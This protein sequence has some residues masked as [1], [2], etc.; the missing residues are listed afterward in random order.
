MLS[1]T[2]ISQI[3]NIMEDGGLSPSLSSFLP[4][5]SICLSV[6]FPLKLALLYGWSLMPSFLPARQ[7]AMSYAIEILHACCSANGEGLRIRGP[8]NYIAFPY[9]PPSDH[10][11]GNLQVPVRFHS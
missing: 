3:S 10:M 9:M 8:L 1:P 5:C 7:P 2:L 4:P 6:P 11:Q